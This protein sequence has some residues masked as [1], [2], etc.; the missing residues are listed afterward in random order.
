ML[1]SNQYDILNWYAGE[2]SFECI[3]QVN[4]ASISDT[5]TENEIYTLPTTYFRISFY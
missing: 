2:R 4:I 5:L 1:L 3:K